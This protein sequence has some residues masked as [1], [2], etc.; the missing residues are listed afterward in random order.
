[1][2]VLQDFSFLNSSKHLT[3]LFWS[4][5]LIGQPVVCGGGADVTSATPDNVSKKVG[6]EL[7]NNYTFVQDLILQV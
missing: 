5:Y 7:D 1:M 3:A 2:A 4:A 6:A